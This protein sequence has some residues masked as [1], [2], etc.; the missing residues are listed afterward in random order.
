ML[1]LLMLL[2]LRERCPQDRSTAPVVGAKHP[3]L[4]VLRVP[5]GGYSFTAC[6]SNFIIDH[7]SLSRLSIVSTLNRHL[8][9]RGRR[10]FPG[11]R[12]TVNHISTSCIPGIPC[13]ATQIAQS[14]GYVLLLFAVGRTALIHHSIYFIIACTTYT[15]NQGPP[16][17]TLR[18]TI[19]TTSPI[20]TKTK[21]KTLRTQTTT[22]STIQGHIISGG[23][24]LYRV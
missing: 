2:L 24:T 18:E 12:D 6:R 19:R 15:N 13:N 23:D 17:K 10:I 14:W 5:R 21:T 4:R 22:N 16:F 11:K 8:E 20:N 9:T 1:L 7:E 3:V